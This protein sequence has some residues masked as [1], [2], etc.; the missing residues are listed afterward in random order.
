MLTWEEKVEFVKKHYE[1]KGYRVHSGLQFGAEL[2]L[3]AD[4]PDLVHSDFC[5]HVTCDGKCATAYIDYCCCCCCCCSALVFP[6]S[7]AYPDLIIFVFFIQFL[8]HPSYQT[9][10]LTGEKCKLLSVLWQTSTRLLYWQT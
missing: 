3:Y 5:I 8:F 7:E 6:L 10:R 4:R 1:E 2:V 9:N